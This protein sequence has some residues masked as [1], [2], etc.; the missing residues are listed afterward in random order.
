[1][2][3]TPIKREVKPQSEMKFQ[4]H[5]WRQMEYDA[6]AEIGV[7]PEDV[8]ERGY[9][10]HVAGRSLKSMTKI[11]IMAEDY[12]WYGELIVFQ[13]FTNGAH[14]KFIH[15][16]VFVGKGE[17]VKEEREYEVFDGGLSKQ[18]CIKRLKD[19]K[20]FKDGCQSRE[21]ADAYLMN[22]LKVNSRARAA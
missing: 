20:I 17:S 4:E 10:S 21:E 9:W 3:E 1:M 6:I 7:T 19:G 22:W 11:Y 13:T 15:P 18:W 5:G 8:L 14:V 2:S 16:P 12:A